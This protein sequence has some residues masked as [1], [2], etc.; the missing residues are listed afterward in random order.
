MLVRRQIPVWLDRRIKLLQ[1]GSRRSLTQALLADVRLS[2]LWHGCKAQPL[3]GLVAGGCF[4]PRIV[5][6][7]AKPGETRAGGGKQEVDPSNRGFRGNPLNAIGTSEQPIKF[8][9][10][11]PGTNDSQ[12]ELLRHVGNGSMS[13][14]SG[15]RTGSF[16][17]D[18][19]PPAGGGAFVNHDLI[20]H[21]PSF[22]CQVKPCAEQA[23]S[24]Y[25][26]KQTHR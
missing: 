25:N 20:E 26:A 6:S 8:G 2:A 15:L 9:R 16:R 24:G 7:M 4:T 21:A 22:G 1:N 23:N 19:S 18:Q 5:R 12:G 3:S 10:L 17:P 13:A 14:E 11:R